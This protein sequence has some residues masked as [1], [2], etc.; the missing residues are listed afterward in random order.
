MLRRFCLVLLL[1]SCCLVPARAQLLMKKAATAAQKEAEAEP[2]AGTVTP[3]AP[4]P[5]D[6][7]AKPKTEVGTDE[8]ATRKSV[9]DKVMTDMLTVVDDALGG[10]W[11]DTYLGVSV[12]RY[13]VSLML[14][15]FTFLMSRLSGYILRKHFGRLAKLT[16]TELDDLVF[17]S[18]IQPAAM[19]IQSVG[20]YLALMV[21]FAGVLPKGLL[22][23]LA[24]TTQALAAGAVFWYLYRLIDVLDRYLRRLASRSDNDLDNA[25]VEV[26]RKSLKVFLMVIAMVTIGKYIMGWKIGALVASAGILGLAVAFA[27]QDTIAN[28]FGTFMLLLDRPF[29]VG[30]RV[31]IG[32][33]D[34]PV[35]SIGFRSTRIRTMDGNLV[36]IPNKTTADSVVENVGRRP[37]IKLAFVVGLVYDTPYA[38]M[39]KAVE[40]LRE[41]L[42]DHQG[43]DEA[44]PP[45]VHFTEFADCSLNIASTIWYHGKVEGAELDWWE[46]QDWREYVNFEIMRRFEE[47]GLEFAFPT[48]TMYLAHDSNRPLTVN[49]TQVASKD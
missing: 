2:G 47:A 4:N 44:F 15:I 9:G 49:T 6:E 21:M 39:R 34:G 25:I 7:G 19:L 42:A 18:A 26:V 5:T 28:V 29:R 11:D 1:M 37:H 27:A 30:E 40:I 24:R 36:S 23:W 46:Y 16:K 35:E 12:W 8:E 33:V 32:D 17:T 10:F 48:Q 20:V 22:Q 41:L 38:K 31:R 3:E 43:M 13:L 45:R 14:L